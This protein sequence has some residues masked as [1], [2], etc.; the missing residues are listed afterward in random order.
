M[1][2]KS[3]WQAYLKDII[4]WNNM[5]TYILYFCAIEVEWLVITEWKYCSWP[6][7]FC[8]TACKRH[9]FSISRPLELSWPFLCLTFIC[10]AFYQYLRLIWLFQV[11]CTRDLWWP[12]ICK[13]K[14]GF[15]LPCIGSLGRVISTALFASESESIWL[16]FL[17]SYLT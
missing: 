1:S 8:T 2:L 13:A 9:D 4:S 6:G 5:V 16:L 12:I 3:V 15:Q 7:Y 10:L 17:F 11:I 14:E